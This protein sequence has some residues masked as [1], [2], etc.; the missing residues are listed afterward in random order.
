MK[1][2][3]TI[4]YIIDRYAVF[5][6]LYL[7]TQSTAVTRLKGSLTILYATVL[8]YLAKAKHY[9]EQSTP[10]RIIK[11]SLVSKRDI[12]KL[13]ES[14]IAAQ[15][16]VNDYAAIVDA[17][18]STEILESVAT[19]NRAHEDK[20]KQ[21]KALLEDIDAPMKR[22]SRQLQN[23]EDELE[24]K[25]RAE[26]LMWLSPEPYVA[27][28]RQNRRDVLTGTGQWLLEDPTYKRWM[29]D[30]SSS[31]IWL[32]GMSGTGK[33]KLVSIIIEDLV[34][35][36]DVDDRPQP[37]YFYCSRSNQETTRSDPRAI[38]ASLARQMSSPKSGAPILQPLL[39]LYRRKEVDGFASGSI[40]I[41]ESTNLIVSLSDYYAVST[42]IVDALD[43]CNSES[44][45]QLLDALEDILQQS[46]GLV[47]IFVSSRE[48]GDLVCELRDYPSLRISS[49][50]NSRD[51][52]LFVRTET[53]RLVTA[54]RLLRNSQAKDD[55]REKIM[56]R[57]LV[58]AN[59]MSVLGFESVLWYTLIMQG[60]DG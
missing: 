28:H 25:R 32:H 1:G 8:K 40:S 41:E 18:C 58:G 54:G 43:E 51:I 14:I 46:S 57:L 6:G 55:L 17:E 15:S 35:Q 10:L 29:N 26:I 24:S 38:L 31:L 23:I 13:S 45:Y 47:K 4:A 34:R 49:D 48:E 2:A 39:L 60:F 44:R 12:E 16:R 56:T 9:F 21:L 7:R 27:H 42:I 33:S 52:E 19:L 53:T 20:Y 37:V 36:C 30:S 11:G 22:V 59:G 3:E 50:R 5:E